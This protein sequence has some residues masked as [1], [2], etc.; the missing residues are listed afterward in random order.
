MT[1]FRELMKERRVTQNAL[2]DRLGVHQTLISQW[3][4]NK[5]TPSIHYLPTISIM[6]RASIEEIVGCFVEPVGD[7]YGKQSATPVVSCDKK[8]IC[9]RKC[10]VRRGKRKDMLWIE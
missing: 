2:A 1:R 5:G 10:R 8:E 4:H 9:P 3:C 6:L 7:G